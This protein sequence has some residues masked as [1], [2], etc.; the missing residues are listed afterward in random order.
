MPRS[1]DNSS[2]EEKNKKL[3]EKINENVETFEKKSKEINSKIN[4]INTKEKSQ[5]MLRSYL[6]KSLEDLPNLISESL[7]TN[8]NVEEFGD[9]FLLRIF[10][11]VAVPNPLFSA[12]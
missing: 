11:R 2:N 5:N 10:E 6:S 1:S 7:P 8:I 4:E 9:A 3:L 12:S